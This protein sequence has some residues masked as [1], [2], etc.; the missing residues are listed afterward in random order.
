VS[1]S[2]AACPA[3]GLEV[4][5]A[6]SIGDGECRC[7]ACGGDMAI[8]DKVCPHCGGE[9]T[10]LETPD[11]EFYC[12]ECGGDVAEDD[13]VCPHC[14]ADLEEMEATP[15]NLDQDDEY[16]CSTCGGDVAADDKVCPH[17]GADVDEIEETPVAPGQ[18]EPPAH[19]LTLRELNFL[20]EADR[21]PEA[22]LASLTPDEG[23]KLV[24]PAR[25]PKVGDIVIR[26][27]FSEVVVSVGAHTE[28]RFPGAVDAVD[29]IR[30][31]VTDRIIFH[32][33]D[34][35]V[36]VY[37]IEELDDSDEVDWNYYVW[38]GPLRNQRTGIDW[39]RPS[40]G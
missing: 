20:K 21:L 16:V 39:Y 38:S 11:D 36:D 35:E 19:S 10:V 31:V 9:V 24:L 33:V 2:A 12:S 40:E 14:G 34:G 26:F 25:E 30:D 37:R 27:V 23:E 1:V 15:A 3:C 29:F 18:M 5:P 4:Y 6:E 28:G 22:C 32:I 7:S 8:D 13:K 17:C